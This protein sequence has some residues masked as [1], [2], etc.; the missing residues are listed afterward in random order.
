[1]KISI[2]TVCFNAEAVIEETIKSVISQTHQDIEYIIIDGK[3]SDSTMSRIEKY[4]DKIDKII[5]EPDKGI[6]DAMNKG[7]ALAS[8]DYINFMNAGD[9]FS[10]P[11]VVSKIERLIE[12]DS[13]VVYGDSTMIGY[14]GERT[15][16]VAGTDTSVISKKPIY[17]HNASFTRT[18]LHK[19]FPFEIEKKPIYRHALDYNNIFTLWHNDAK[20]QK[21]DVNVVTWEKQGASDHD[22]LNIKLM[23]R[24]SHQFRQP[25]LYERLIFA[26]DYFKAFRRDL[27]RKLHG[28]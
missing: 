13:D 14:N 7:V 9:V 1:M 21:A 24:I 12:P 11:E 23:F 22:M 18:S 17:R 28:H 16:N 10:S 5:S 15:V 8:G 26:Y 19:K 4:S 20:F 2:V 3:S 25:S 27:M 6:Y